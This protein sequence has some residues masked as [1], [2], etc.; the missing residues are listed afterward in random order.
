M[1][2][3]AVFLEALWH[4]YEAVTSAHEGWDKRQ[5]RPESFIG[6]IL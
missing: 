6:P 1:S 5:H 4:F 3:F 2:A